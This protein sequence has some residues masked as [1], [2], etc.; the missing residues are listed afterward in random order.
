MKSSIHNIIEDLWY[1]S[2]DPLN[3]ELYKS[4]EMKK[5]IEYIARHRE[6]LEKT[7]TDEQ[8]AVFEKYS[9][10]NSEFNGLSEL[11]IFQ[12]GFKLGAKIMLAMICE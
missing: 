5:L 1:G 12:C 6:D 2:I 10:C 4:A 7:M 8:K 11:S 9:D 3:G